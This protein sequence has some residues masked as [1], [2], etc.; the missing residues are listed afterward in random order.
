LSKNCKKI[1]STWCGPAE[2]FPVSKNAALPLGAA[3]EMNPD[4]DAMSEVLATALKKSSVALVK[5]LRRNNQADASAWC[6]GDG[7]WLS[8]SEPA[9]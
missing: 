1:G 9:E 7:W 5:S 2:T 3:C 4:D 6:A 8:T